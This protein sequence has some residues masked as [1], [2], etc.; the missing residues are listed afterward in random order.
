MIGVFA[1]VVLA[2]AI[3]KNVPGMNRTLAYEAILKDTTV[4]PLP[5]MNGGAGRVG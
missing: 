4:P 2:D 3:V 1:D 5:T